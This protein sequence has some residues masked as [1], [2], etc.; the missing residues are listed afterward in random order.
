MK[1]SG[2]ICCQQIQKQC[3]NNQGHVE[4]EITIPSELITTNII[5]R[6]REQ[7]RFLFKVKVAAEKFIEC[8]THSDGNDNGKVSQHVRVEVRENSVV[9]EDHI[10]RTKT[11]QRVEKVELSSYFVDYHRHSSNETRCFVGKFKGSENG[12]IS[13]IFPSNNIYSIFLNGLN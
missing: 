2:F 6:V 7:P 9:E 8:K 11:V 5:L 12:F 13:I 10:D 4:N 3:G 1:F